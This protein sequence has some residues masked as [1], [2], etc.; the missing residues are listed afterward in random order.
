MIGTC[1]VRS[2]RLMCRAVS[3][4]SISGI[5][6]SSRINAKSSTSKRLSASSPLCAPTGWTGRPWRIASRA[7]RLSLRSS[8]SST[9]AACRCSGLVTVPPGSLAPRRSHLPPGAADP[10]RHDLEQL[11]EVDR[12]GDVVARARRE[13]GL[14]VARHRLRGQEHHGQVGE[15]PV[16]PDGAGG[17]VAV[18]VGHHGVHQYHVD[19]GV[20]AEQPDAVGAVVGVEDRHAVQLKRAGQGEHVTHVVVDDQHGRTVELPGGVARP[21]GQI[22]RRAQRGRTDPGH[23]TQHGQVRAEPRRR[24]GREHIRQ[25]QHERRALAD[26]RG[27]RD[28]AAEQAR[29]LAADG[30]AKAG[31]AVLAAGRAV[32]LLEGLEDQRQ[33]VVGDSDAGV[34]DAERGDPPRPVQRRY[35]ERGA[36]RGDPDGELHGPGVGELD[37]VGDQVAQDLLQQILRNLVSNAVKF[38]DAGTVELAIG[39]A[40]EGATF[41]VPSLDGARRVTAFSVHDTGIGISDDKLA[42][43]FEA[44]QQADG[45]TSR[46]Y[47][48]TGL[49]LS[50]SR[51]LARLLGGTIS[52]ASSGGEGS[53]FVLY[54]PDVFQPEAAPGFGAHLAMMGAMPRIGTPT[55]RAPKDLA[56]RPSDAARQ[57]DGATVL[58]VDD[59]VRNVFALTSALELHGMTVLYA[60]NGA[61]G[62]RLLSEH[63]EVDVVLMDA[64]MPDQDGNETTRAIRRNRRFADLPVVFLTAKAMPGDRESSL[65]AGASDY[66]TKPVDLDELLEVMAAW[67]RGTGRQV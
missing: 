17:L 67:V 34:V 36:L 57:L 44:F 4:P 46:K 8:T 41:G 56:I 23:C 25:V 43:I 60:D 63:P 22:L 21:D 20:L 11:I 59:D 35:A 30:Q 27:D 58:I 26:R 10:G 3:K 52:V 15:P 51:E 29:Q 65:A 66:I 19:L 6:A 2:R 13:A 48:G 28:G 18:L 55:L 50:I 12:L 31:T 45:T 33:L 40:P 37:R 16:A 62:V 42:L 24:L 61:D 7:V 64:M 9:L 54:L 39:V 38:T 14:P 5:C 47:G 1:R 49:G 53:T 32:R